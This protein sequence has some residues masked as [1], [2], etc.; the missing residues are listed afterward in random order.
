MYSIVNRV[1]VTSLIS[2]ALMAG[3][4]GKADTD[5]PPP[6]LVEA[7]AKTDES[8]VI[9]GTGG[10]RFETV[11]DVAMPATLAPSPAMSRFS[12]SG[13]SLSVSSGADS[14]ASGERSEPAEA[15]VPQPGILTAAVW[16]DIK[17]WPFWEGLFS[18]PGDS[19]DSGSA[20]QTWSENWWNTK[21]SL[22]HPVRIVGPSGPIND[23][24]V[25]L[26]DANGRELWAARSDARGYAELFEGFFGE[27][28]AGAK[29]RIDAGGQRIEVDASRSPGPE[30]RDIRI[31]STSSPSNVV[32]VL[33]TIDTTGSMSDELSYIQREIGDVISRANDALD[34]TFTIRTGLTFYRDEGDE[35]V[36]RN[37]PFSTDIRE[38]Q[39]NLAAQRADGGGDT[40]EAVTKAFEASMNH[41]WSDS[42]AARIMF[43]VLDAEPHQTERDKEKLEETVRDAASKGIRIIPVMGSDYGKSVEYLMRNYAI[44]TGGVFTFLT[45][46]SG[47]G[48]HHMEPTV[49]K[50][51]V[52]KLNDLLS[53]LIVAY[54]TGDL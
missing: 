43:V 48:N 49:G 4:A 33:F 20:W 5:A 29:I 25:V 14:A 41:D 13:D 16:D 22:R 8:A 52:E 36:V 28:A 53:R 17:N 38:V 12:A 42:A 10:V 40:P 24:R 32:D 46:H 37:F 31:Q 54:V 23:A 39:R 18:R 7:E 11:A 6:M 51:E 50:Y 3:C 47:V 30:R 1:G 21:A 44:A 45:N 26:L 9:I 19:D 15:V 2:T 27:S 34:G 35:Y